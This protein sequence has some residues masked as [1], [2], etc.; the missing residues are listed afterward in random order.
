MK[1]LATI[2]MALCISVTTV[3][4]Q[5]SISGKREKTQTKTEIKTNKQNSPSTTASNDNRTFTFKGVSFKMIKVQGGTFTMGC[6]DEQG[7]ECFDDERPAQSVTLS[8]YWMCE[9]EVTQGLW[10]AVMDSNPSAFQGDIHPVEQVSWDDC[11]AFI[12][13][14][15]Q[16]TGQNFRLPTEAEWEYAAR[17][18]NKSRGY[19]YA[20]SN[21]VNSVAWDEGNSAYETHPVKTKQPNELGLYDMSGNVWEWCQDWYGGY[22]GDSQTNPQG[23]STGSYRVYR[24]GSW[25]F[26]HGYCRVLT[27][28]YFTPDFRNS[29]LGFRLVLSVK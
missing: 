8:D 6:T 23:P 27:R 24:G 11:Q 17:G 25:N 21:D 15:N 16:L 9:T 5:A 12:R 13:N 2:L 3:W 26:D 29:T 22:S 28:N 7:G 10:K 14:L 19:E 4:A 18:G 20:G 1:H